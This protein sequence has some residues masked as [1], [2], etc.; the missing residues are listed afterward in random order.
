MRNEAV[1]S[2]PDRQHFFC[3]RRQ[4]LS[5]DDRIETWSDDTLQLRI[6][7]KDVTGVNLNVEPAGRNSQIVCRIKTH[8]SEISFA[9][10]YLKRSG[11]INQT[12][13]F[14]SIMVYVH[15]KLVP[16]ATQIKFVEGPGL[17]LCL[18][19]T[20]IGIATLIFGLF[21][22]FWATHFALGFFIIIPSFSCIIIGASLIWL[23]R[24]VK[25][26]LYTPEDL[27]TR[28]EV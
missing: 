3:P 21:L 4:I 9:N 1:L 23:F 24:P 14:M 18:F 25:P 15:R 7:F 8:T 27:I 16:F 11:Y 13:D 6:I 20:L 17:R 12:A 19:L 22:T 26:L 5:F 28:F 2:L 10:R